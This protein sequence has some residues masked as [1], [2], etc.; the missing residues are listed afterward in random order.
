MGNGGLREY[1]L[2]WNDKSE[3][4]RKTAEMHVSQ[5]MHIDVC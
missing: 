2:S 4:G 3:C 5:P 1:S